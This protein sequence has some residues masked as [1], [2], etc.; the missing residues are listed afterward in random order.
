[1]RELTFFLGLQIMHRDDGI[2]ISQDKYVADILKK[3]DF[4]L[5]KTTST[6][7]ETNK[8]L[9][10][11][12]EGKEV[13]VYLNRL[14]IGSLMYLTAS[15]PDIMF[16]IYA[17][18][19]VTAKMKNVN[20]GAQIQALVD[21]MKV[22]ITE[23]SI[24]SNLSK[25]PN[26]EGVPITSNDPLP[27]EAKSAQVKEI[28][29]LKKRVK[30]LEQKRKL[31]TS[32]LKI[33][34][35]VISAR[36]LE[37]STKA[38]L[39]D[40]EDASKQER[41]L[42]NID[43]D[44]EITLVDDTQGKRNEED[45]FGVNDLNGDQVIVDVTAGE[46]VEQSAKVAKKEVSTAD[47][48]T[49]VGE[50]V[51]T[52]GIKEIKEA[53]VKAITTAA[54]IVTTAGTRPKE[55]GIVMQ[56]PSKT[57]LLKLIDSSQQPS[58]AKNK[59][60]GEMVEPEK[61]LKRKDQIMI[62]EEVARNLEAQMQAELEEKERLA[63]L[64]EEETNISLIE[65]WDNTQAMMDADCKLA[66]EAFVP[67]D[68]ELVKGSEKV[69]EGSKKAEEGSSKRSRSNLE[70]GDAKRERF[71]EGKEF[72]ELK[73]CLE[74]VHEDDDD[75]VIIEATP[76]SSKSP[77]IVDYKI[78]KEAR[79]SYFKIIRADGDYD[80]W[81]MR[82]DQYL[83]HTDYALWEVIVNGDAPAVIASVSSGA[84]AAIPLK[85]IEQKIARRNK[86]KAKSTLLLAIPDEHLLKFH[87]IKNAKTLWEAIKTMLGGNKESKKMQKTIL[88]QQYKNFAASRFEGLDKTYDRDLNNKSDV[89]ESASDS[90][91]NEIK[92]NNNQANDRY[93][94]AKGYHAV[95]LYYIRNS[96]PLRPDL[97]FGRLDDSVF[98][99][100]MSETVISVHETETSACK[101]S[102]ESMEKYKIVRS[103]AP[104]IKDW[105]SNSDDEY[106]IK[107]S[108][109]QNKPSYAKI[110]FVKSYKNS[111]KSVIKQHTYKPINKRTAGTDINFNKKVNTVK[112]KVLVEK[113]HNKTPYE[114]LI[115]RSP[116]LDFMRPFGCLVTI[117]NTLDHLGKFEGKA[118]EEFLVGY[119]VNSKVF[120]VFNSRTRKVIENLHTKF[121]ENKSNV[122]RWGPKWLF[123]IDS[124]TKSMNYEP[125]NAGNQTNNHAGIKIN[126][127]AGKARQEKASDHKYILLPFMPSN[128]PL[129]LS[130]QSSN[131]KDVD[132]VPGKGN[133]SVSK[134]SRIDDQEKTNSSTQ[135]DGIFDDVYN[136]R[137]MGVEADINNLGILTD[138]SL[139]PTTRVHKDHP[140]E[141]I[142]GDLNLATQ[143]R[144]MINFSKENAMVFR[145]KK[146]ERG[147]VSRNK[148]RLVAQGYTYEEGIVYDEIFS[149]VARIEAIR[150]LKGQPKLGLWYP[151]DSPFDLEAFSDSDYARASL[152]R[153][154]TTGCCQFLSKR[155][156]SW[157]CKKQ[158][159]FANYT[160]KVEYVV[161]SNCC[162]QPVAPTT[163]KQRLARKNKLKNRGTLLMALPGKHQLK[164][165]IHKDAKTLMEAIK[166]WFGG[167]KETKKVQK[168]LLKQQYKNF[169][170]S[171]SES[172]DQVHDRLQKII[173]QLEILGEYL[174]QED[175]NLK[176]LRSLPTEWRTHTLIWRNKTDLEDQCLDDMFNRLKIYEAEVK[177]SSSTS[178][179]TQN[180]AFV[181]SQNTGSTNESV[182]VVASVSAASAKVPVSALPNDDL[183]KIDANYLEE[184][185][186]KWQ[187]A[188]L[189]MTARRFLQRTGRNLGANRYTSI[190]FDML[191]VECYNYHR[192][193][194][195]A[196]ECSMMVWE[197]MIGAFMQKKNQPTMPSW[198]SPPQVL[199]VLI[200][201]PTKPDK[202]LS[203]SNRPYAP[204]IE[205]WVSD[206]ENESEGEHPILAANLKKDIPKSRG[207]ENS[208][209]RKA[210]FVLLTRSKLF[211]LT[212]ARPVT[213]AVSHNNVT[214]PR[215]AKT[216]GTKSH[217]PLRRI[218]NHRP[219]PQASNFPLKV[220][221]VK[222]S[223]V[224]V[225]KG[226]KR[227]WVWKPKCSILDHGNPQ[228]TLKDK[229]VI[230][231]G[232]SRHMTWNMSYL[233]DFEEINEGYVTF[234]GNP[235]GGKITDTKCI[236]LSSDFKLPDENH[237]LL[238]VPR[239]NNM[240]NVDLKNI[241]PSGDL[242]CLFAKATLDESNLWHRRLGHINFKIMNKLVKGK[243]DGKADERF[244]VGYSISSKAFRVFN[245]RTQTV[246]ETL[247]I[248]FLENKSNVAWSGP[249]WLFDIDTLTKSMN[250]QLV[251]IENQPNP[252]AGIQ[253]HF[254]TDK[255]GEG[256]V[257]QYVLFPLWFSGSKDPQ[258]TD[259]D[260]TFKVKELE[261]EVEKPE[262]EV[263]VS[264]S[265]SANTK[266]HDDKTKREAKG[267]SHV[268][269]PV[270]AVGQIS[271]NSTNT[272]S[273][274]A[275]EDITYSDDE[276]DVGAEVNFSNLETT[277]T[278][279]PIPTTR[280]HKNH[281]VTQII[282]EVYV[283]Q[284][285]GFEESDYPDKVY[286][287]DIIFGSTNKD[288]CKAF[289]KL[290]KDKFQM[291]SMG[292]LTF[293]SG[294][295][296]KQKPDGIFFSQDKYVAKILRKFGLTDRKSASTPI[297]TKKPLLKDL[298][299]EDVDV[300]TYRS[301][302]GS[303]MYL[304]SSRPD[305]MFTVYA[306][307]RFQVTPKAAHLH[308]VKQIFKYLKGKPHLGLWYPKDLPFNLVAY[309]DSDYAGASLDKKSTTGGCQFL[310]CR[311]ISWQCKKHTVVATSSTEAK[312]VAAACCYAQ[313]LWIQNQ[314]L[315]YSF[316]QTMQV[317][318]SSMKSLEKTLHVTNVSSAG[319]IT[320]PQMVLNSPCVSHDFK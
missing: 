229:R 292:E 42:D 243:F 282:E 283:C 157:Q 75:D 287:D 159:L 298:D 202:D 125:V 101:S 106:E 299:G 274:A 34:R 87:G 169:T 30:K 232:C 164:F 136:D 278:V 58:Q 185:D 52:T 85:T 5:V 239:E 315:D 273:D 218:I 94:E 158:T 244:L 276:E 209:N 109:E 183:K 70:Q 12:E 288:L 48:V 153:K 231:S 208:R 96:M 256:N 2:F 217:S 213:T 302:I 66:I 73:I 155:L 3:F 59:G 103:S 241:V 246:Q 129:S 149:I 29:S 47:L 199:P 121:L 258:N 83:T 259:D 228:H 206:L 272:F 193:G 81:S 38:S 89:F 115:R 54:T 68:I 78:Y 160:T 104:I 13:D 23:A 240:Y 295:H 194:H 120:R 139:I 51:T 212:T 235:K 74:I 148:A 28:S 166:K 152:D 112:N 309:S 269:T 253:E 123:D 200:M 265:S 77:T 285:P 237:V 313:V 271:T 180:I 319:Y 56:E 303:L 294:L 95:P 119:S 126:V 33:L 80:L 46:N 216:V 304:T 36:R 168:T 100:A 135:D 25:I 113:P 318:Q 277:I 198:H 312:Y 225:V 251:I 60:K 260:T 167:N 6:P 201:S 142:I 222:A 140:K 99:S 154:S 266:K 79:K 284:P 279:S 248:N 301:M 226:V 162:G 144:R 238:R 247:H 210:C 110:N 320:I 141:Q 165:N 92:E 233:S 236:V 215:L 37:P 306:C 311:L 242:T 49:T 67:M 170:S 53:K 150:Y 182:S 314:L 44:V 86:L 257:Q 156:I 181:S 130:T 307:A 263:H 203:H 88:K 310:G 27:S 204:L 90:S 64:K 35:N 255:A 131:D 176:F 305:I 10:K 291:S 108:I 296:V 178:P 76:L 114:L 280:V 189:T 55:K 188:M 91:V 102:K 32:V 192:R 221:T 145:N 290:I 132:K 317:T 19:W 174:S 268:Y 220:T 234:G 207:H 21:K 179:T 20:G 163:T 69:V 18:L 15:R 223:H 297:D 146:A 14:M 11:D 300:H 16:V 7:I 171:S 116:N 43:Q 40:Q 151:R 22:I 249:T 117:L 275:L 31:R 245:S 289:E 97:S 111:R 261:F 124:L 50:V 137:E 57:P 308:A 72:A 281:H 186:L 134:G 26:R 293:F 230:D 41:M 127:N 82:M 270:P 205:G 65:S 105:D 24:R 143:T 219:S 118:D 214:R 61:P 45:I 175:I 84:E 197:A 173:S 1:M 252:S 177:S 195:F 254:D 262:S 4:S 184:M 107:P 98:K 9:L 133:E 187:M 93:K 227:N 138:V 196:R 63:R 128:S 147:I 122:A 8:A 71:I 211:P 39:G 161:A 224:N 62:D 316:G 267:K 190:G 264:P 17:C 250:Y 191:K 286:V 172:L